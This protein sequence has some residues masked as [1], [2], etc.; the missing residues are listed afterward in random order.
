MNSSLR[1]CRLLVVLSACFFLAGAAHASPI[2]TIPGLAE[3]SPNGLIANAQYLAVSWTLGPGFE[4]LN[5]TFDIYNLQS[6][7][8]MFGVFYLYSG[9][10]PILT[11]AGGGLLSPPAGLASAPFSVAAGTEPVSLDPFQLMVN[12]GA[13]ET[14]YLMA[15]PTEGEGSW[16]AGGVATSDPGITGHSDAFFSEVPISDDPPEFAF[17]W[18]PDAQ[19]NL[20]YRMSVADEVPGGVPE[21]ATWVLVAAGLLAAGGIRRRCQS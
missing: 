9:S 17:M 13:N 21:P 1:L 11:D 2:I 3:G 8:G 19:M 4:V 20:G 18:S 10:L 5:P 16:L 12:L 6:T 15:Y 7:D 14:Y